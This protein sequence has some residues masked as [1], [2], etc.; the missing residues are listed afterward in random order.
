[1]IFILGL[2]QIL[3]L[4][5]AHSTFENYYAFRGCTQLIE[6]TPDYGTCKLN[7]GQTIKIVRFKD[8]WYLEGDLPCGFL[9][10]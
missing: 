4:R 3:F 5:K 8:K 10:F 7:K 1:V 2:N 9:C 6:K